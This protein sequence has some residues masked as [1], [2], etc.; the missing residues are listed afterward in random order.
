MAFLENFHFRAHF[1]ILIFTVILTIYGYV[2]NDQGNLILAAT[3]LMVRPMNVVLRHYYGEHK[4]YFNVL[5]GFI[6][7]FLGIAI[8]A[9]NMDKNIL[10]STYGLMATLLT[11][12]VM[13]YALKKRYGK[14]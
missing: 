4:Y 2:I 11:I 12:G 10:A 8:Y 5:C 7:L 1:L 9:N 3:L 14:K 6:T 13:E